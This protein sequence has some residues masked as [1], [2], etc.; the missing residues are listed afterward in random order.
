MPET[1]NAL[2]ALLLGRV[3]TSSYE[4]NSG[5][6]RVVRCLARELRQSG[7]DVVFVKWNEEFQAL[8]RCGET[9]LE[10]LAGS[11]GR[12]PWLRT[13]GFPLHLNGVDLKTTDNGGDP[14]TAG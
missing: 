8:A 4:G 10:R 14:P 6:Q 7:E 11:T 13:C 12:M 2:E 3:N 9:E 5:V 1:V